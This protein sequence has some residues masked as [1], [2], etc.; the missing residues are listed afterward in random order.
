MILKIR[1]LKI[2]D[3]LKNLNFLF[4]VLNRVNLCWQYFNI[5]ESGSENF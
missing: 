3:Y 5:T 2:S 1:H 4:F